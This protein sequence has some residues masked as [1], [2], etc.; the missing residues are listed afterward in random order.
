MELLA[1]WRTVLGASARTSTH[2]GTTTL[3]AADDGSAYVLKR[4]VGLDDLGERRFRLVSEYRVLTHLQA[5]G[6]PVA[7]PLLTDEGRVFATVVGEDAIFTLTPQLPAGDDTSPYLEI[8]AAL[9]RLHGALSTCPFDVPSWTIDLVPR[10]FDEAVRDITSALDAPVVDELLGVL[11][12][13]RPRLLEAMT[14]L[15]AQRIHGDFHRGNILV[16]EG[17][18][19]GIV[20]LDH[21]PVGPRIYDLAYFLADRVAVPTSLEL[22]ERTEE[23]L[24]ACGELVDGYAS[25]NALSPAEV[26]AIGPVMLAVQLQLIGWNATQ[27]GYRWT[28]DHL[29]GF[30]WTDAHFDE[31][32]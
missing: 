9:G 25:T 13:R 12:R 27:P 17:E 30:R 24:G 21:L 14:G 8:G 3:V 23:F 7:L 26:A 11:E 29:L 31:L 28:E 22:E 1:P 4:V 5:A 2:T 19:S 10:T 32:G 20:D 6:L 15:P 16:H 18:V